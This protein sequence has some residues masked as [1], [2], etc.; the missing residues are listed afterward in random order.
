MLRGC[1]YIFGLLFIFNHKLL[2][3]AEHTGRTPLFISAELSSTSALSL[4]LYLISLALSLS[5]RV[6]AC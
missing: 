3:A 2:Y 1:D 4:Y 5:L 6:S